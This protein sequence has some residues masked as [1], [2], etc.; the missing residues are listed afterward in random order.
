MLLSVQQKVIAGFGLASALLIIA[1]VAAYNSANRLQQATAIELHTKAVQVKLEEVLSQLKDA[2]TGQ[3][4]YLLTGEEIYLAPYNEALP[5]LSQEI[6]GLR[7]LTSD[8]PNQQRQLNNLKPLVD[9]KLAE[10]QQT[11]TLRKNR[12]FDAALQVVRTNEGKRLM[13]EIRERINL[14]K[15]EEDRLLKIR[16]IASQKSA[17]NTI[18]IIGITLFLNFSV[19]SV[20]YYLIYREMA[21]RQA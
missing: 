15:I 6:Q 17:A 20:V 7:K 13:D 16:N 2:E 4:G 5:R 19:L 12:G 21:S 3:R 1:S 8:N 18:S 9:Q 14:M 11:I 10:L